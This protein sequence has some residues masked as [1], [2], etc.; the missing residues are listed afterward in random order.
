M[1]ANT[2]STCWSY[3]RF[4]TTWRNLIGSIYFHISDVSLVARK[5]IDYTLGTL[6]DLEFLAL[7]SERRLGLRSS[8]TILNFFWLHSHCST[9]SEY[10]EV[11]SCNPSHPT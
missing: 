4:L 1:P 10:P 7:P 2:A 5:D 8:T 9:L 3:S 6:L 11:G